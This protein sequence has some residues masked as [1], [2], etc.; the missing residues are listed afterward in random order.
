MAIIVNHD[1]DDMEITS[2]EEFEKL[3][4][5]FEDSSNAIRNIIDKERKNA[6]RINNTEAWTGKAANAIYEKYALLNSNY[7][8][9]SYSLEVYTKFLRKVAED[10][11]LLVK[12]QS[13]NADAMASSLDVNS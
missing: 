10:Y 12:E 13:A 2:M 3:I 6:E 1:N 11:K 8:Q 5:E 4:D 7:E 9:I